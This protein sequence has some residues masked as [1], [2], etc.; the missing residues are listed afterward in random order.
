MKFTKTIALLITSLLIFA[1]I[2]ADASEAK[3]NNKSN[4]QATS[5]AQ[6]NDGSRQIVVDELTISFTIGDI[7]FDDNIAAESA[8]K[9]MKKESLKNSS[10]KDSGFITLLAE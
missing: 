3:N 6:S 4:N 2:A 1:S 9:I 8:Q 7:I 10:S 5:A